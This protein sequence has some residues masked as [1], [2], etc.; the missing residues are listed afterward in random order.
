[1]ELTPGCNANIFMIAGCGRSGT[2]L[3]KS[4][5]N[6]HD[7]INVPTETFFFG[8]ISKYLNK[9]KD[10]TYEQA[11]DFVISRWWLKE[12]NLKK[13]DVL[14]FIDAGKEKKH[15]QISLFIALMN[16]LSEGDCRIIG[17]KTPSHINAIAGLCGV[18]PKL[19]VLQIVRDPRAVCASYKKAPVGTNQIIPIVKEW[20]NASK[21]SLECAANENYMMIRYEDLVS[22]CERVLN[23]VCEFLG[24]DFSHSL[25]SFY[26]RKN[27]GYSSVQKHHDATLK[28]VSIS[29]VESWR[30]ELSF[31]D[32]EVIEYYTAE[33]MA[34]FGYECITEQNQVSRMYLYVGTI[35][36]IFHKNLIRRPRQLLKMVRV[37]LL[38]SW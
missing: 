27:S 8:H 12:T 24:V 15:D 3:L 5:L 22:D 35:N 19:K 2:T 7:E 1:M 21:I 38:N 34:S 28:P 33:Y 25:L 17:E 14:N 23:E 9:H 18:I 31:Q 26:Q 36:E 37:K 30:N 16:A 10:L 20:L 4:I 6:Y 13:T 11:V 32:I 29:R